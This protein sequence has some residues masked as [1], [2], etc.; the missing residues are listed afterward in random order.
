VINFQLTGGL[1]N[2]LFIAAHGL[3]LQQQG[4]EVTFDRGGII[5]PRY[6]ALDPF[7]LP[8]QF[9]PATPETVCGYF[10]GERY[11]NGPL[12]RRE[13]LKKRPEV[14][15]YREDLYSNY[16][17]VHVR[18][19]DN[20]SERALAFH[21]N[22]LETDY[23]DRA[24]AYIREQVVNPFFL[25]F[26]DDPGWCQ[27]NLKHW[28]Y[29]SVVWGNEPHEDIWEMSRCPYAIIANSS[30]SFWGSWLG[31]QKIVVAPKRWFVVPVAGAEDIVPPRWISLE[32]ISRT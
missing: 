4:E 18:L 5:P 11:F 17:A 10:Q 30:F 8:I 29:Y 13:F 24:L 22:L 6:Y 28:K 14:P 9:A 7:D 25:V 16:V 26:S 32:C 21:G 1:G 31:P 27:K 2:Q 20:L 19:T 3:T 23:Y 15:S 12:I